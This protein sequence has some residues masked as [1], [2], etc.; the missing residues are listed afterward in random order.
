M[1]QLVLSEDQELL[2]KTVADFADEHCSVARLRELR[3]SKDPV[4]FSRGLWKQMAELG[5]VGILLPEELGGAEMGLSE[6][7]VILEG[8]GRTLS[9]EPFLSTVLLGS[10]ALLL[11]GGERGGWLKEVAQGE[12][13][14]SLAYQERKSRYDLHRVETRAE[15]DGEKLT[16]SGCPGSTG[17]TLLPGFLST[18]AVTYAETIEQR[19]GGARVSRFLDRW[20]PLGVLR[21]PLTVH[22]VSAL[23]L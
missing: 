14:L 15:P 5:W 11:G 23:H 16:G 20:A 9:P 8:L 19:R 2:A 4:G 1:Q 7:V 12:R 13:F 3:D 17:A 18:R 6:L 10:Q 21:L 22:F